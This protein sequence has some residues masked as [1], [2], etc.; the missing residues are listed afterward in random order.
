M[1]MRVLQHGFAATTEDTGLE[2][3]RWHDVCTHGQFLIDVEFLTRCSPRSGT[4]SCIYCKS[5][6]YLSEIAP[7]FPWIHFYTYEHRFQQPEY[8]PCQPELT[9]ASQPSVQIDYNRTMSTTEF[10]KDMA[11]SMGQRPDR[12]SLLMIC[13]G[14][15]AVRQLA[16]HVL[17]QPAYTLMDICGVIPVDYLDGELILPINLPNNKIFACLVAQQS[18]R[19]KTYDPCTYK[20]EIGEQ[21]TPTP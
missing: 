1:P 16:L 2:P 19:C 14:Q 15:D 4:A 12:D 6:Q 8:D 5:P 18:A 9:H 7:L 17:T 10:T 11:R 21:P 13:H 3:G 20:A